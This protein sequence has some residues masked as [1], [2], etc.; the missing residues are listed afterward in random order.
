LKAKTKRALQ[1]FVDKANKLKRLNLDGHMRSSGFGLRM[2][3]DEDDR[4]KIEFDQ[5]DEKDLDASLFTLRLFL[6]QGEPFSFNKLKQ[7]V[8]DTSLSDGFKEEI[9]RARKSYFDYRNGYP[10][11]IE[12]NFFDEGEH[13]TRGEIVDVVLNGILGHTKNYQLR[14]KYE[15]WSR[16]EIRENILHQVFTRTIL[17][18]LKLIFH[19]A[20]KIEQESGDVITSGL[21]D[22]R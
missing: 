11:N 12:P 8:K 17:H 21:A 16:D 13:P 10:Q 5:P 2:N 19:I 6:Q 3:L 9:I 14:Q 1:D 20:E 7:I 18:I 22:S 4:W 15:K